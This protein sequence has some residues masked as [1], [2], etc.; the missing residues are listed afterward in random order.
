M[1][2]SPIFY[3]LGK[4]VQKRHKL[5]LMIWL[6]LLLGCLPFIPNLMTP[7]KTMGFFD[8]ESNS[9]RADRFL[10]SKLGYGNQRI[11]IVYSSNTLGTDD[12]LFIKQIKHSLADLKDFPISHE[13]IYPTMNNKQFAT[14]KH[15]AVVFILFKT[16]QELRGEDIKHLRDLIKKPANMTMRLGGEPIFADDVNKQ[17]V[18]DLYK[19]DIIAAPVSIIIMILVFGS[20]VAASIPIILGGGCAVFILTSLYFL[21]HYLTLSIFTINISLLLGLCLS[22]DYSLFFMSRFKEE[23]SKNLPIHV[24][25][26]TTMAS[27]GR[28]IFYSGVA[29]FISLSALLI[30][31]ISI[32]FSIGV[33]GLAAVFFAVA[34]SLILLPAV[35]CI[36]KGGVNYLPIKLFK[37]HTKQGHFW[38]WLAQ[39]VVKRPFLFFVPSLFFLLLI[40]MPFLNVKFG[41]SDAQILPEKSESRQFLDVYKSNFNEYNLIPLQVIARSKDKILSKQ[42][43]SD[44]LDLTNHLKSLPGLSEVNSLVTIDKSMTIDHYVQLYNLEEKIRGDAINQLLNTTTGTNFTTLTL[45]SKYSIHSPEI[46]RLVNELKQIKTYK[47][48]NVQITGIPVNNVEVMDTI[49]KLFPYAIIWVLTLTFLILLILLHSLIMPIKAIILNTISLCASYGVLVF[50]FQEG[51]LHN[52]LHFEPQGMLDTSLLIIIFCALFGFSMDYEVFLLTRMRESYEQTKNTNQSIVEGIAQSGRIIT[53]AA[54][55]VIVLCGSFMAAE[56]LMVKEFGLGIAIAIFVDAFLVRSLLEPSLMVLL[57]KWN[58]YL[59]G[60]LDK[61]LPKFYNVHKLQKQD[62]KSIG[63]TKRP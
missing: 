40:S 63:K 24:V 53:S 8:K 54:I 15:H 28:A 23:L 17:T 6:A 9:A 60:W 45:V 62:S 39:K 12:P 41:I 48:L 27:A 44:L 5:I 30:F 38:R 4:W 50:V 58:W 57:G 32:L 20:L 3:R 37:N 26:A 16:K 36:V 7:F 43:L 61:I 19:A 46:K 33:G 18:T 13:I 47:S 42:S 34:V 10:E 49:A 29:V 55:I 11:V 25:I 1:E 51:H 22:L 59:P 31:P 35:L 14:N 56:V 52:M 2:S 21:A